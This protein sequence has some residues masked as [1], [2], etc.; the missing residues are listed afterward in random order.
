MDLQCEM[1]ANSDA[2]PCDRE[3]KAAGAGTMEKQW[4]YNKKTMRRTMETVGHPG[5]R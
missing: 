3:R 5:V 4:K 2:R 1:R